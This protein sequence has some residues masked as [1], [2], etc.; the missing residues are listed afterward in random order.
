MSC[1]SPEPAPWGEASRWRTSADAAIATLLLSV[2]S[3]TISGPLLATTAS[4][5]IA[6]D[7]DSV[8]W[9]TVIGTDGIITTKISL[10][11]RR[12]RSPAD[13]SGTTQPGF[14]DDE[15]EETDAAT[16]ERRAGDTESDDIDATHDDESATTDEES[17]NAHL[18]RI[19]ACRLG[20]LILR[21]RGGLRV[22][23]A[24]DAA[25]G[26]GESG[27]PSSTRA[28]RYSTSSSRRSRTMKGQYEKVVSRGSRGNC[29]KV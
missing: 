15:V 9:S 20:A 28:C 22:V 26:T 11:S 8:T 1:R 5:A 7:P 21:D 6:G 3:T 14:G 27:P 18:G 19:W 29:L 12:R 17:L 13:T 2:N 16:T 24:R 4:P 23:P 10:N 25:I